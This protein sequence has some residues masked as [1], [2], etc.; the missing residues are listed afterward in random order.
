MDDALG[1]IIGLLILALILGAFVLPIIALV[2]SIRTRKKLGQAVSRI[3]STPFTSQASTAKSLSDVLQQLTVRVARLEAALSARSPTP[4]R[5]A[6]ETIPRETEQRVPSPTIPAPPTPPPPAPQA[7]P[8]PTAPTL[9]PI[10]TRPIDA[11]KLESIIGRRWLGWAAVALILFATA[12][13]LKHAFD[14]R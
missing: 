14:N 10:P 11:E 9:P 4:T 13:F 12:F 6:E 1:L 7:P 8:I 2:V 5:T 3:E